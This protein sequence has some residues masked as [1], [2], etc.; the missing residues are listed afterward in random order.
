MLREAL[1]RAAPES[2]GSLATQKA[3]LW[4]LA[5][6]K[7]VDVGGCLSAGCRDELVQMVA[8]ATGAPPAAKD[9]LPDSELLRQPGIAPS[10]LC[11]KE[12]LLVALAEGR[13]LAQLRGLVEELGVHPDELMEADAGLSGL[14][15]RR[16]SASRRWTF[17]EAAPSAHQLNPLH[18]AGGAAPFEVESAGP[19]SRHSGQSGPSAA[20]AP[21]G[22]D[23][24]PG[25]CVEQM[26]AEIDADRSG[27]L[28]FAEFC[29]WWQ[30][31]GGT[32]ASLLKAKEAFRLIEMRDGVPGV[33]IT[34]LTEVMIAIASDDWQEAF[35]PAT[36][37]KYYTN[38][39]TGQSSWLHPGIE[40][41]APYMEAAGIRFGGAA[42]PAAPVQRAGRP[43]AAARPHSQAMP[44]DG[45]ASGRRTEAGLAAA[46]AAK[47]SKAGGGGTPTV[48]VEES[49]LVARMR[50]AV[51][52]FETGEVLKAEFTRWWE[53]HKAPGLPVMESLKFARAFNKAFDARGGTLG[54][55]QFV[56][57]L[58]EL[59]AQQWE[60]GRDAQSGRAYYVDGKSGK[61]AW[62]LTGADAD[63]W[64]AATAVL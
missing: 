18:A 32:S 59:F 41:V 36:E 24:A 46:S 57:V 55:A 26:F 5:T 12:E 9:H 51:D 34:E 62:K 21:T 8:D 11:D 56:D 44:R 42:T 13:T 64:L 37:R 29:G 63:D 47:P 45:L 23:R 17:L 25:D 52:P 48:A 35:D 31:Q 10:H 22:A 2:D 58:C 16:S 28:S 38:P 40:C 53:Q 20:P 4:D 6:K 50:D 15:F 39:A 60:V 1:H 43:Q 61:T 3:M 49:E 30:A 14:I 33:T 19:R 7:G 54:M 27:E